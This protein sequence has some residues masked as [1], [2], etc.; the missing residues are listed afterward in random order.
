MR[1]F[2]MIFCLSAFFTRAQI[3]QPIQ[4]PE[5]ADKKYIVKP[6][7]EEEKY[8]KKVGKKIPKKYV[9]SFT[10]AATYSK[11]QMFRDG[12]IYMSWKSMED[13]INQILDSIMPA[14]LLSKKINA[15]IGRSSEI[16]AYCLYDG[17]MIINAGL[18]AEV[19][20]EAALAAIMGHELGHYMKSHLLNE[21][22]HSLKKSKRKK[23]GINNELDIVIEKRGFS[24]SLELEAD[25]LGFDIA[26]SA[27]Y[28]LSDGL[29]NFEIFIR[30]KEYYKKRNKSELAKT[31]SLIIKTGNGSISVN[32]LTKLL[33]THPDEKERIEKLTAYIKS[34]TQLKKKQYKIDESLFKTLQKQAKWETINKL[35][36]DH[37]YKEC[38]ERSFVYHLYEPN[39]ITFLY[40]ITECIRREC[41]L[42]YKLKKKG[43]LTEDF[44]SG[45]INKDLGILQ[46]LRYVVIDEA[47]YKKIKA[48]DL[49][50][51][52]SY[53]FKSYADAFYYFS[54]LMEKKDFPEVYLLNALFE[55]DK[56][57]IKINIEKYLSKP[58]ASKKVYATHYL[59]GT[60]TKSLMDNK[61]EIVIIPKVDYY[62]H[63]SYDS[64]GFKNTQYNY[65]YS[66][67]HGSELSGSVAD[68]ISNKDK[69]LK[70]V[71]V[72]REIL[73]NFNSI[74][75]Y[76]NILLSSKQAARDE[77][78]GYKVEHYYRELE[79]SENSGMVDLFRLS[80]EAWQFFTDNK[81]SGIACASYNSHFFMVY[82][83]FKIWSVIFAP[84]TLG[85][86]LLYLPLLSDKGRELDLY[87]YTVKTGAVTHSHTFKS[88]RATVN[89]CFR[90]FKYSKKSIVKFYCGS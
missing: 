11:A 59:N 12:E 38:L 7:N 40:Y 52:S 73:N 47:D 17:S 72:P 27:N 15:F 48:N 26:K 84:F 89:R 6:V 55:N 62:K 45:G 83:K 13:Y 50:D 64:Y 54:G 61:D 68:K 82:R 19:K 36:E 10:E 21:Y 31:D 33:S 18:I 57:K 76:Q 20:S 24:Q 88:R 16:N 29:S 49:L 30:E 79:D 25:L 1:F 58:G 70:V 14:N 74:N 87:Y 3:Y 77:N 90:M 85:F 66:E 8:R 42:D 32:T 35:F 75:Q 53:E 80:P 67:V 69:N 28:D 81:I 39:D 46:D 56:Q 22:V 60:M 37:N 34:N 65:K 78:E 63:L 2:L 71:S 51:K 86:T 9:K 44:L 43:F 23:R 41:L 4:F 5:K